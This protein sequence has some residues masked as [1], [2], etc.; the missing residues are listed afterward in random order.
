[1]P[2]HATK[3]HENSNR[4]LNGFK[5]FKNRFPNMVSVLNDII[6]ASENRS[7]H[8]DLDVE[9]IFKMVATRDK[10]ISD[11]LIAADYFVDIL[12]KIGLTE[13]MVMK[14]ETDVPKI[15]GKSKPFQLKSAT[16]N[17][18]GGQPHRLLVKWVV[19]LLLIVQYLLMQII[20]SPDDLARVRN[21]ILTEQNRLQ[22]L[23]SSCTLQP[24]NEDGRACN[25]A[26]YITTSYNATLEYML[27][28]GFFNRGFSAHDMQ[29][30]LISPG[31]YS[32]FQNMPM[33]TIVVGIICI[34]NVG[35]IFLPR[36]M[37]T[38]YYSDRDVARMLETDIIY[39]PPS[40]E[41]RSFG[42]RL[43]PLDVNPDIDDD[44]P[45]VFKDLTLTSSIMRDPVVATD[46]FT[47]E[48]ESIELW[49]SDHDTSPATGD[50]MSDKRLIPNISLRGQIIEWKQHKNAA[51]AA[52]AAV[53]AAAATKIQRFVRRKRT[54]KRRGGRLRRRDRSQTKRRN[55]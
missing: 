4:A 14:L 11:E 19:V 43:A 28:G 54:K 23:N 18:M 53:A 48:R 15:I 20:I 10:K 42:R 6:A 2:Q 32:F 38:R 1:M 39:R 16:Q 49:L 40:Q 5:I 51:A 24:L 7:K 41:D 37:N 3:R 47:Y 27:N 9:T 25:T 29:F 50:A 46:G 55:N 30:G 22:Q 26:N 45:D 35:A 13:E 8:N 34:M 17:Q 31:F 44:A 36:I 33:I 52:A 12:K 21:T